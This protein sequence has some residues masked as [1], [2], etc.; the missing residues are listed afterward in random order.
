MTG[1]TETAKF[2]SEYDLLPYSGN[3]NLAGTEYGILNLCAY[4]AGNSNFN[5]NYWLDNGYG[6]LKLYVDSPKNEVNN[7]YGTFVAYISE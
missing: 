6:L 5:S 7:N 4:S 1:T 2:Y 3:C